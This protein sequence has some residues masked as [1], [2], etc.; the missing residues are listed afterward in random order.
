MAPLTLRLETLKPYGFFTGFP[1]F[2][3]FLVD[4]EREHLGHKSAE[5]RVVRAEGRRA[6]E[7]ER[8]G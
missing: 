3:I 6:Q 7:V 8:L 5:G 2:F 1:F 4:N